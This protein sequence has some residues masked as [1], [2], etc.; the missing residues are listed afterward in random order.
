MA[1]LT[2]YTREEH[3]LNNIAQA[4]NGGE[5]E[6]LTPYT[7]EEHF[8]KNIADAAK[9]GGGLPAST[10]SDMGKVLTVAQSTKT[11]VAAA[12][13]TVTADETAS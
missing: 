11:I 4:I 10:A 1:N 8:L 2:P 5:Q 6:E 12:R 7:R 9:S 3:L 13:Q